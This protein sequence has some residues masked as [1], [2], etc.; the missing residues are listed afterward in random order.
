MVFGYFFG[1]RKREKEG[2][3]CNWFRFGR[4]KIRFFK[5]FTDVFRICKFI[6]VK[7]IVKI[8]RFDY[9]SLYI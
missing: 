5:F 9:I 6:F 7:I 1:G 8:N 3:S 4:V 2:E